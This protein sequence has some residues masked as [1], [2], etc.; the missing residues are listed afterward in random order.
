VCGN[1]CDDDRNGYT[2]QDDPAC[3][4]QL[5]ATFQGGA[6]A[7]FLPRL[8][9]GP[10]P[11]LKSIDNNPVPAGATAVYER[12]FAPAVFLGLP[13][14]N[15][16]LERLTLQPGGKGT[17]DLIATGYGTGDV[18]IFNGELVVVD[19]AGHKLHRV[20]ADGMTQLGVVAIDAN[21]VLTGCASDG[22]ALYLAE[23]DLASSPSRFEVFDKAYTPSGTPLPLPTGLPANVDRCL[24]FAWA[25]SGGFYGLFVDAAGEVNDAK[26]NAT[27]IYPF[28]FD[29]GLGPPID[30]GTLHGLGAFAP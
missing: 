25:R 21:Y 11:L 14:A 19:S 24:D 16:M 23:H 20:Q 18:C 9:L 22:N 28:A 27:Q 8:V 7:P 30:A 12:A 1:G 3:S 13:P 10:T 29:G 17:T 15:R 4:V 5:L 26:L 2:D 6:P